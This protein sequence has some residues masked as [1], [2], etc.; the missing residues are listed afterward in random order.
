[1]IV[2]SRALAN[3]GRLPQQAPFL[4]SVRLLGLGRHSPVSSRGQH[5]PRLRRTRKAATTFRLAQGA[6]GLTLFGPTSTRCFRKD[7]VD[8]RLLSN[9]W[10]QEDCAFR[11][12]YYPRQRC[13]LTLFFLLLL[14][15]HPAVRFSDGGFTLGSAYLRCFRSAMRCCSARNLNTNK[16]SVSAHIQ[17]IPHLH[18]SFPFSV[19]SHSQSASVPILTPHLPF[20]RSPSLGAHGRFVF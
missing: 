11:L 9:H 2:D 13:L 12:L 18:F 15:P 17:F 8:A 20:F 6:S 4:P 19:L 1:M 7:A 5:F 10:S 3:R 16:P 14:F